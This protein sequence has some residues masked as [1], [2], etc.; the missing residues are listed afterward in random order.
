[1]V[2]RA[3]EPSDLAWIEA[4]LFSHIEGAMFLIGNLRDHGFGSDH[5]HGLTL[6]VREARDGVFG[7][8]NSGSVMMMAPDATRRDWREA[9]QLLAG[10]DVTAVLGKAMQARRFIAANDI[11]DHP[12]Q[13][14]RDDPGFVLDLR[15]V[16]VE[17]RPEEALVSLAEAPRGLVEGWRA[18][19]E[20]EVLNAAPDAAGDKARHDI[21]TYIARDSHRVLTVQGEPVAMSGF[22]TAFDEAVQV[23]GVYTPPMLRGRGY[24]RRVVGRHLLQAR[25]RGARQGVLFAAGKD[26][27]RAYRALGFQPA[28]AFALVLF[29]TPAQICAGRVEDVR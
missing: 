18:A 23:G 17:M 9:G 28:D 26:A 2:W 21:A 7:I 10:R 27:A 22:N 24:A 20:V 13:L 3:A 19:Y 12:C 4:L 15:D 5:P 29:S 16:S 11:G 25:E 1:M 8:T 14:D 6:W